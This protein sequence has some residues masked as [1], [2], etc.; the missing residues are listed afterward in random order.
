VTDDAVIDEDIE[1]DAE[2]IL[3]DGLLALMGAGLEDAQIAMF[4]ET[5]AARG[6][7][8]V[9]AELIT[10]RMSED[11]M[12]D[13]SEVLLP[14]PPEETVDDELAAPLP[15]AAAGDADTFA[16]IDHARREL[17]LERDDFID[18]LGARLATETDFRPDTLGD[19]DR[20]SL[21]RFVAAASRVVGADA[22]RAAAEALAADA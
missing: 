21:P 17:G 12:V 9:R 11:H 15:R 16:A 10:L 4:L 2:D 20:R 8:Y 5:C 13:R 6:P 19:D 14:P 1:R 7:D 3:R 18:A 22:V